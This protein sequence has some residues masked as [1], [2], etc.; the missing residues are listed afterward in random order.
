LA[1]P[2]LKDMKDIRKEDWKE[3]VANT[4]NAVILDVRTPEEYAEGMQKKATSLN[5]LQQEEFLTGIEKLDKT[6]TYFVYCR[7][8]SRSEKACQILASRGIE[9]TY[10]LMG[11]MLDWDGEIVK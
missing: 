9:N 8:G 2:E 1:K 4:D 3:L 6:K 5:F 11:G 7:S 10:N